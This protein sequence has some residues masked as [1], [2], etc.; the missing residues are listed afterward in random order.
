MLDQVGRFDYVYR[1]S[2]GGAID[3]QGERLPSATEDFEGALIGLLEGPPDAVDTEENVGAAIK[4][5]ADEDCGVFR[6]A[7][8]HRPKTRQGLLEGG[9]KVLDTAGHEGRLAGEEFPWQPEGRAIY[10]LGRGVLKVLFQCS[11]DA[12]EL[13]GQGVHLLLTTV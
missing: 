9:C 3:V 5:L 2:L 6:R 13:E 10:Q 7:W 12:E 8:L 1:D 11:P 4:A